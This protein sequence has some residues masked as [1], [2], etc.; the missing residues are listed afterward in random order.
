MINNPAL[1]T[2]VS[3][4]YLIYTEGFINVDTWKT[5]LSWRDD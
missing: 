1:Q 2:I 4:V 5:K 3:A